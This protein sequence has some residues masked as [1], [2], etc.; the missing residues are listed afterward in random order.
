MGADRGP[1]RLA[2]GAHGGQHRSWLVPA[3]GHAVGAPGVLAPPVAV[4][5]GGLEELL[6]GLGV[7]VGHQVAGPLP[8]EDGVAGYAPGGAL[9]V[10]L[11]LQEVEEEGAVVESPLLA[12]PVGEGL[13]E[14]LAGLG[15]TEEVLL[16]GGLLV[17]VGR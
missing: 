5:V 2:Q 12:P 8:A 7:T 3:V 10:D 6:I 15:D 4:P 9:V 13:A 14:Q 16:V 11:P 17:G 1:D